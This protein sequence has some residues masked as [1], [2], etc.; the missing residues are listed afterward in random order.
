MPRDPLVK[1]KK[2][3]YF[4]QR[5]GSGQVIEGQPSQMDN[6]SYS[7]ICKP[8]LSPCKTSQKSQQNVSAK[9]TLCYLPFPPKYCAL[10]T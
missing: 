7:T 9:S 3:K 10:D 2:K 8:H 1:K 6:I 4:S 5:H